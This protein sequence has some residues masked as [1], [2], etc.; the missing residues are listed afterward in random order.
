MTTRPDDFCRNDDPARFTHR[1]FDLNGVRWHVVDAGRG[2]LVILL[3]GFP[4]LW[5]EFRHQIPALA[6]A[7]YRVLAPDFPGFGGSALPADLERYDM[8]HLVADLVGMMHCVGAASATLVGHDCGSHVAFAAV[9]MR[10]DLFRGAVFLSTPPIPRGPVAPGEAWRSLRERTGKRFYQE[11]FAAPEALP[12]LDAD[13]RKSLRAMMYSVSGSARHQERWRLDLE[14]GEGILDTVHDPARLPQWLS[15]QTLD[16][17]VGEYARRGFDGPLNYYRVRSDN[18]HRLAFL[19]G[20]SPTLPALFVGGAADPSLERFQP[21]YDQL[22]KLL[23]DLR[24]KMLLEG[25]GHGLPEEAPQALNQLLLDFLAA[26]NMIH[27]P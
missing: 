4:Y 16:Y 24:K 20:V 9:Q 22:E 11:V 23:P 26:L 7:G 3:H 27:R 12:Q 17:Y 2:P 13:I 5:Y 25:V 18:W 1:H 15:S 21:F 6:E 14:P 10:P 19:D 8:A